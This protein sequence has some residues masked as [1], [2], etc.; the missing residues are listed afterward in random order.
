MSPAPAVGVLLVSRTGRFVVTGKVVRFDEV[1]GYGFVAPEGGGEDVFMHVN[2]LE[3]D[4]RLIAPGAIV[5][6][7]V[8]DGD[9]GLKASGVTLV[10]G[11]PARAAGTVAPRTEHRSEF[12]DGLCDVLSVPEFT[13]ELTEALLTAAPTLTGA[14]I[15]QVR[16]RLVSFAR[17]HGWIDSAN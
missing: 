9:R 11:A 17:G 7:A 3:V 13:A 4:K 6:F 15:V 10:E 12:D 16:Q 5:E 2:D 8:E 14:Q 1:R